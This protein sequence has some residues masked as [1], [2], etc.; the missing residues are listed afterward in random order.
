M[1]NKIL[2]V[3]DEENIVQ[4]IKFN[5]EKEGYEVIA[6][7]DGEKAL[8]EVDIEK[9]K[10]VILD[11]MLPKVDGL[12]VCR[13]IRGNNQYSK[14]PIIMLTAK[15]EELDKVLGLEMGADDY[16]TK[17]FSPRELIAR[18]KAILRRANTKNNT[19]K[20]IVRVK[21]LQLDLDKY[22]VEI[23]GNELDLTPKEFDLMAI[24]LSHPGQVFSRDYLLQEI[25]GYDYH[26]DTRTVDVHI[27]R[28]RKKIEEWS[29]D[30]Y[31]STVRGV[32]YK[33]KDL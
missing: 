8:E 4:L 28:L 27:R 12:E 22:K 15:S 20:S 13:K 23:K 6:A 31:I 5:L 29:E 19:K 2:V 1:S 17:P 3:D 11:L 10:L 26:G 30:D 14:L 24:F 25:W 7:Y 33:L 16:V 32:G 18:V 9:P 21:D